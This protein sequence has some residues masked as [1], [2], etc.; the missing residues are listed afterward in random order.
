MDAQKLRQLAEEKKAADVAVKVVGDAEAARAFAIAKARVLENL[1]ERELA[2]VAQ[3]AEAAACRGESSVRIKTLGGRGSDA[4]S[5]AWIEF[6][7]TQLV[8]KGFA[9]SYEEAEEYRGRH[10]GQRGFNDPV[11]RIILKW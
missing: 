3:L 8:P 7:R 9:V 5:Q 10:N 2:E 11:V 1:G 6:F 4:E